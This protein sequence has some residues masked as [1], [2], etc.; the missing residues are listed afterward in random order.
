MKFLVKINEP[1]NKEKDPIKRIVNNINWIYCHQ[2]NITIILRM[3]SKLSTIVENLNNRIQIAKDDL[4][5]K[6]DSNIYSSSF[7]DSA[8][9]LGTESLIRVLT[10]NSDIF[11]SLKKAS[12]KFNELMLN[13]KE[14]LECAFQLKVN[15]NLNTKEVYSL[16]EIIEI[17]ETFIKIGRN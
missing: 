15:L 11:L 6:Y 17:Y 13:I 3:F 8:L 16:K 10:T 14:I 1:T 7:V 12:E 2:D 9:F 4:K 5:Y